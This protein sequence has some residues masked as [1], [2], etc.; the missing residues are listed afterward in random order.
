M[1]TD[2]RNNTARS[3]YELAIDDAVAI[4]E[5][6]TRDGALALTHT[7]VPDSLGGRGVG[8]A[9]ARGVLEDIRARGLRVV[10]LC[11]FIASYIQR[12]PEYAGLVAEPAPGA[13]G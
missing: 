7:E 10:P 1:S 2:V 12:H 11:P 13:E 9:L 8:S 5:Y 3:R 4:V 6:R